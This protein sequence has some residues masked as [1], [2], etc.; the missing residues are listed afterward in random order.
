MGRS[1]E[2]TTGVWFTLHD[3]PDLFTRDPGKKG[4]SGDSNALPI[5][6]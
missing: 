1:E 6:S 5:E 3:R 2:N 4:P